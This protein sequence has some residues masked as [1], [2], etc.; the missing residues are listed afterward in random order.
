MNF[1]HVFV[2][3]DPL[4]SYKKAGSTLSKCEHF[5]LLL[6]V[7]YLDLTIKTCGLFGLIVENM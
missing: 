3:I 1:I 2:T 5:V 4:I 7:I 6:F